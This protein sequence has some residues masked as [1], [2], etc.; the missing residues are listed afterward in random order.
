MCSAHFV[1]RAAN[2][3][4]TRDP[5]LGKVV[6]YQLSYCRIAFGKCRFRMPPGGIKRD[7]AS[8]LRKTTLQVLFRVLQRTLFNELHVLFRNTTFRLLSCSPFRE[9]F[10]R[11]L[12]PRGKADAKVLQIFHICKYSRWK[13]RK[14]LDFTRSLSYPFCKQRE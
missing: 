14:F 10:Q 12:I 1:R 6:L 13:A 7:I 8:A 5:D 9:F 3:T 2:E 11:A 4:R